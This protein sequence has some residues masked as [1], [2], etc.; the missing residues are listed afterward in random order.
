[1]YTKFSFEIYINIESDFHIDTC[2]K[3]PGKMVKKKKRTITKGRNS[4]TVLSEEVRHFK[5][6]NN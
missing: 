5:M 1:M 2:E 3:M 4:E 6:S